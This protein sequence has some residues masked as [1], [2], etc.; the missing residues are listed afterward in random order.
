VRHE[1][2]FKFIDLFAGIG[3]F[4]LALEGLGGECVFSSEIDDQARRTYH[5][6]FGI[7]PFGDI[8]DITGPEKNDDMIRWGIPDHT[9]LAGGFPCQPFS[10][11]GVSSRNHLGHEHGL[12][13]KAKG[14][15][16][17]DI[18]RIINV[19]KPEVVFLENVKNIISHDKG[20]TFQII[21]DTLENELGYSFFSAV[22]SS[23]TLVP[24]KRKRCFIVAFREKVDDF[25]FPSLDGAP[26][27]L[28]T[29]LETDVDEKYTLSDR[30]WAGH[31][32]R[33]RENK[34]KGNGFSAVEAD[35]SKPANTLVARYYK[36]GKECLIPQKGKNPRMLTPREC[37]RLQGFSEDY[38]I[39]PT[40][41]AAYKQFGNA[42]TVPL[43][44]EIA[45]CILSK[46]E[47]LNYGSSDSRK[48]L[49]KYG[50]DQIKKHK[51]RSQNQ[52]SIISGRS[53]L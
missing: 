46:L 1:S 23:E 2:K 9:I 10:L 5:D 18:C 30:G 42:V 34:L 17:F 19:K 35:L 53:P 21:R 7:F 26:I 38:I 6:N 32:R 37:A 3:G 25:Q 50:S 41:T 36:D 15:L 20:R 13:D 48:T 27:A 33:T 28:S 40:R 52:E 44:R 24:Q 4:H 47:E 8:R 43:V 45:T 39:H 11:A 49:Q 14:T 16:F 29:I 31:V 12:K 51:T 22:L